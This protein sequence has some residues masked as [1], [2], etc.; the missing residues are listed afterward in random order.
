MQRMLLRNVL[1]KSACIIVQ[2]TIV[3][4]VFFLLEHFFI[5]EGESIWDTVDQ[6]S[7]VWVAP[8]V[9]GVSSAFDMK[10]LPDSV[11]LLPFSRSD[12]EKMV[13]FNA[14]FWIF[15]VMLYISVLLCTPVLLGKGE[16]DIPKNMIGLNCLLWILF[17][18]NVTYLLGYLPYFEKKHECKVWIIF[19]ALIVELVVVTIVSCVMENIT[20]ESTAL[21]VVVVMTCII[22]FLVSYHFHRKYFKNMV[23]FYADYEK[24][25]WLESG[26]VRA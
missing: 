9:I 11:F 17:V 3:F 18:G 19:L 14:W 7:G 21:V 16:L 6:M 13:T 8:A 10:R 1:T 26:K 25:R 20:T 23:S 22:S 2:L 15:L 5:G 24:S 12:R 4:V